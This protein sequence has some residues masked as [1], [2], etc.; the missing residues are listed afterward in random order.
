M[1]IN[2]NTNWLPGLNIFFDDANYQYLRQL[3]KTDQSNSLIGIYQ[4]YVGSDRTHYGRAQTGGGITLRETKLADND[5]GIQKDF[6]P[7]A[8]TRSDNFVATWTSNHGP[9]A[10]YRVYVRGYTFDPNRGIGAPYPEEQIG[11]SNGHYVCPRIQYN[12]ATQLIFV[13]WISVANRRLEGIW[14]D[15]T[16]LQP[17]SYE[18]NISSTIHTTFFSGE[19]EI[20]SGGAERIV[21]MQHGDGVIVA[22]QE[23]LSKINFYR[24]GRPVAGASPVTQLTEYSQ[25]SMARY[26]AVFDPLSSHIMLVYNAPSN[27][28]YGDRIRVFSKG[29]NWQAE[30]GK[31]KEGTIMAPVRLNNVSRAMVYPNIIALPVKYEE[32]VTNFLVSWCDPGTVDSVFYNKFNHFFNQMGA[33]TSV[34]PTALS[35]PAEMAASD[36][37]VA[38]MFHADRIRGAYLQAYGVLAYVAPNT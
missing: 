9:G 29:E 20:D 36:N 28:I 30:P 8:I 21:V 16:T 5:R 11:G 6:H 1:E 14:L 27:Y 17:V 34:N 23:T 4:S 37:Q 2:M 31:T 32:K 13:C 15:R 38:M 10:W 22:I 19:A 24:V 33:E 18:I 35:G 3:L 25:T 7:A 12:D 26:A